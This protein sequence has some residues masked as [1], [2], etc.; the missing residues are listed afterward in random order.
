MGGQSEKRRTTKRKDQDLEA[1]AW[2]SLYGSGDF[3]RL[4]VKQPTKGGSGWDVRG[5]VIVC[6]RI[7][8]R[9]AN[10]KLRTGAPPIRVRIP[11]WTVLK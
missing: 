4:S 6:G 5:A 9:L 3:V 7:F 10:Q 8:R 11:P 1:W 2:R